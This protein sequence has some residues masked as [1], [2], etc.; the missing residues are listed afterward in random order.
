MAD[1]KTATSSPA[2]PARL[3]ATPQHK[4]MKPPPKASTICPVTNA[5]FPA[6]RNKA[7]PA[8]FSMPQTVIR[9]GAMAFDGSTPENANS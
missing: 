2:R 5:D 8:I 1:K 3:T 7:T 6:A 4:A 9:N